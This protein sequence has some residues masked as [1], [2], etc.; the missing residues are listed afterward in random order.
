MWFSAV[1][2]DKLL[3]RFQCWRQTVARVNRS[4]G[5]RERGLSDIAL[6]ISVRTERAI[7][8]KGLRQLKCPKQLDSRYS[9]PSKPCG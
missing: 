6:D 8:G 4:T 9:Y 7:H 3:S 5:N 2:P 1:L